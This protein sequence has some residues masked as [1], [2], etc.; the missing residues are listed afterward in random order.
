MMFS[1]ST[2]NK[3]RGCSLFYLRRGGLLSGLH[4]S[5]DDGRGGYYRER[6]A[7]NATHGSLF[8]PF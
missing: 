1:T 3:R 2:L 4:R 5:D 8:I 6:F 7:E